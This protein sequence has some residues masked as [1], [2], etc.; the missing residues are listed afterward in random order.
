M[1]SEAI[2]NKY[3]DKA[4]E[5]IKKELLDELGELITQK[6]TELE[7]AINELKEKSSNLEKDD[8]FF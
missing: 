6:Y 1:L 3:I 4:K 5:Q 8:S 7:E 2:V